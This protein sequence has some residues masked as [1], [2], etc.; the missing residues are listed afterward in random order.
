MAGSTVGG[1]S[2]SA[3]EAAAGF[4]T[5]FLIA[6]FLP[7]A[8]LPFIL[9]PGVERE[10]SNRS[11]QSVS[12]YFSTLYRTAKRPEMV[13]PALFIVI[14]Q[15]MPSMGSTGFY[16]YTNHLEVCGRH[17]HDTQELL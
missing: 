10:D 3:I 1:I 11:K 17:P 12:E 7:L 16:Y 13:K 6:L 15:G 4:R 2:G 8:A 14:F 9:Q 5:V